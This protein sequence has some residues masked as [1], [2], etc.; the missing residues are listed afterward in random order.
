MKITKNLLT[1]TFQFILMGCLILSLVT[2]LVKRHNWWE[3][4]RGA[5]IR[6]S[7]WQPYRFYRAD[8]QEALTILNDADPFEVSYLRSRGNPVVFVSGVKGVKMRR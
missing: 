1:E 6:T 3:D 8:I 4:G 5:N 2:V 7:A